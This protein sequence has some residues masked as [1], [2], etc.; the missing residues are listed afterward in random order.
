MVSSQEIN[1]TTK[2]ETRIRNCKELLIHILTEQVDRVTLMKKCTGWQDVQKQSREKFLNS[3][4]IEFTFSH[5]FLNCSPFAAEANLFRNAWKMV[6][7]FWAAWTFSEKSLKTLL[8]PIFCKCVRL[9]AKI[10]QQFLPF[11]DVGLY[12]VTLLLFRQESVSLD[13]PLH[14]LI[15]LCDFLFFFHRCFWLWFFPSCCSGITV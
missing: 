3:Y 11:L 13:G 10:D 7:F 4:K 15:I 9:L 5:C 2:K 8:A 12:H 1:I 6:V 14:G